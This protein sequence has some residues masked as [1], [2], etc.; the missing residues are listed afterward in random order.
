[1]ADRR[2]VL[3]GLGLAAGLGVAMVAGPAAAQDQTASFEPPWSRPPVWART[4]Q[5]T[6]FP[7]PYER[8]ARAAASGQVAPDPDTAPPRPARHAASAMPPAPPVGGRAA[9]PAVAPEGAA[10]KPLWE[11]GVVAGAGTFPDYPAAAENS[12]HALALPL[13]RYR[14]DVLRSDEKGL[15]RG[16][17]VN[18]RDLELDISLNGA[19]PTDSDSAGPRAGMPDLDWMGEVGPRLQVTLARAA[20]SAKIDLELPLRAV[21]STDFHSH[22]S[23]EG[24]AFEPEIAWQHANF[25]DSGTAVKVGVGALFGDEGLN[26]TFYEVAPR[27]ATAARP[28]YDAEAGYMGSKASLSLVHAVTPWVS[29]LGRLRG[30]YHGGAANEDSPLFQDDMTYSAGLAIAVTLAKSKARAGGGE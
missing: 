21:F 28:A 8:A 11:L 20:H 14:G 10:G 5:G 7:A 25:L 1:M 27:Y 24:Y 16:R 3:A 29:V 22:L 19:F 2:H 18:T 30:D 13:I 26:D 12:W 6:Y 17:L 9:R 4:S 15:L 23:H